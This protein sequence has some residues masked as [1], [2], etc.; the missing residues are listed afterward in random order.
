MQPKNERERERV[1]NSL[2]RV[3]QPASIKSWLCLVNHWIKVIFWQKLQNSLLFS[4]TVG[5]IDSMF[6][7]GE[8]IFRSVVG[9]VSFYLFS[10]LEVCCFNIL[11]GCKY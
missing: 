3:M 4:F 2:F 10:N 5:I 8:I 1:E 7:L 9:S 11:A 6:I